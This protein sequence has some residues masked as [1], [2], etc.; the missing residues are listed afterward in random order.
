MATMRNGVRLEEVLEDLS[1]PADKWQV[2][3]CVEVYEVDLPTRRELY[4]LPVRT[5]ESAADVL[6]TLRPPSRHSR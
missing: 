4:G 3:A 1:Y 2:I 6:S 5:Y